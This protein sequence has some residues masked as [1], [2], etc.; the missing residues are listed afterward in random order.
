LITRRAAIR[1]AAGALLG[2][3]LG[4]GSQT[5]RL[6]RLGWVANSIPV[7]GMSGPDPADPLMR[8]FVHGLRD[9]GLIEGRNIVI[10]RRSAEGHRER[11]PAIM[12]ELVAL[13]VDV[14]FTIG[15]AAIAAHQATE[16][17]P[18]VVIF[19]GDVVAEGFAAS[20]GRPSRNVT[21]LT[22]ENDAIHGKRLQLLREAASTT[23]RVAVI[24]T[25]L[26]PGQPRPTWHLATES[27]ARALKLDLL[28]IDVNAPEQY[29]VAFETILREG[30]NG[31]DVA[32]T[33]I[34]YVHCRTIIDFAA[35]H[36]LPAVY[37]ERAF[38]DDGGLMSY[39]PDFV[40]MYR[41]AAS[42]VKK[43][44]DGSKPGDLP[45]EQPKKF[46]LMIN[47]RAAKKIGLT[48]SQSLLVQAHE[49]IR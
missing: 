24:A 31:L 7:A 42:F 11:L 36:R 15:R 27:A 49:V 33:T 6:P 19:G 23:S 13:P 47:A 28:W 40:D 32:D 20:L 48:I 46:E 30:S 29:P 43:V 1:L 18:I 45:I 4:A 34:N 8:A 22:D 41:R 37:I 12:R 3:T 10:E 35:K 5:T 38:V 17:I 39:G 16:T 14:I 9:L 26:R 21:G 25:G 2:A 44:L